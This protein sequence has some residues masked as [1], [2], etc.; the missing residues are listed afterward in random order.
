MNCQEFFNEKNNSIVRID[1]FIQFLRDTFHDLDRHDNEYGQLS[2]L[3]QKERR[4]Y[5]ELNK[6][7]FN[8]ISQELKN[9]R[10]QINFNILSI[11]DKIR[12]AFKD[13]KFEDKILKAKI[14]K[15]YIDKLLNSKLDTIKNE[16]LG[17]EFFAYYLSDLQYKKAYELSR[18]EGFRYFLETTF[19]NCKDKDS[20]QAK[21]LNLLIE[22]KKNR[23]D[24]KDTKSIKDKI[25]KEIVELKKEISAFLC[26]KS[27]IEE[28]FKKSRIS[29]E[30]IAR[31]KEE[32]LNKEAFKIKNELLS[33]KN[34]E[35]YLINSF[36]QKKLKDHLNT[37]LK[38]H[39]IILSGISLVSIICYFEYFG[40]FI[41]YFPVLSG[42][43]IFYIGA[44]LLFIVAVFASFVILPVALYPL[45]YEKYLLNNKTKKLYFSWLTF[46]LTIPVAFFVFLVLLV[47]YYILL[48]CITWININITD[49]NTAICTA[50]ILYLILL[51]FLY[52]VIHY[53]AYPGMSDKKLF[54]FFILFFVAVI[55]LVFATSFFQNN[56]VRYI[57]L[58]LFLLFFYLML[59]I[60]LLLLTKDIYK[61]NNE[62]LVQILIVIVSL[63]SLFY[64]PQYAAQL[65]DIG[66][67]EYKSLSIEKSALGALPEKIYDIG[68]IIPFEGKEVFSY[69]ENN[70]SII[71]STKKDQNLSIS[72]SPK[73]LS[74]SCVNN[75]CKDINKSKNIKFE[76]NVL[77]YQ[78]GKNYTEENVTVKIEKKEY[79]TYIEKHDDTVWLHNIKAISTLGKFYYLETKD[80]IRFELDASKI[81]SRE[82]QER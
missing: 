3:L 48:N 80:G 60:G 24:V 69:V 71:G 23:N 57:S 78:L 7:D 10:R 53:L 28:K 25:K 29:D 38:F 74:F 8:T 31:K 6:G 55:M 68:K 54:V 75:K 22:E 1:G 37:F 26:E 39:P 36:E 76:N 81:I 73:Y 50:F 82:K 40:I 27:N 41:G 5:L 49:V 58:P 13:K 35:Y 45:H 20:R 52:Y 66:N 77:S 72:I 2:A 17:S 42:S 70:L 59:V 19:S 51:C 47:L 12:N 14:S 43:D 61:E 33:N 18:I 9:V 30:Y 21:I 65:F 11:K 44:L 63:F 62:T 15:P 34:F 46:I 56:Y 32:L 67:V 79:I 64:C 16:L 4:L